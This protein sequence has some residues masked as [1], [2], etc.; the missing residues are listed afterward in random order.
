MC[1]SFSATPLGEDQ[2]RNGYA[3]SSA[4]ATRAGDNCTQAGAEAA[5]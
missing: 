5:N 1:V 3:R 4:Q 2:P